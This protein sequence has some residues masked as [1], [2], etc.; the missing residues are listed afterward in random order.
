[1]PYSEIV[2]PFVVPDSKS[3]REYYNHYIRHDGLEGEVYV[4]FCKEYKD[5]GHGFRDSIDESRPQGETVNACSNRRPDGNRNHNWCY[6]CPAGYPFIAL[7]VYDAERESDRS[8][9]L[10][11]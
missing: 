6:R 1:M 11:L 8:I 4:H 9:D 7:H 10:G 3:G 2:P 5:Y